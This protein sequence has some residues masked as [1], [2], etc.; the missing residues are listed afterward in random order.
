MPT[1]VVGH[2]SVLLDSNRF[3]VIGGNQGLGTGSTATFVVFCEIWFYLYN[4]GSKPFS[5][6][7]YGLRIATLSHYYALSLGNSRS[8]I[9][10]VVLESFKL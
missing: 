5:S 3:M 10:F 1:G 2:C 7:Y 8:L 4:S 6:K 9:L